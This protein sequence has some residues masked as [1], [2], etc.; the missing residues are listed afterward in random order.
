MVKETD[1]A[2]CNFIQEGIYMNILQK[3]CMGS[4]NVGN[5]IWCM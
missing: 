3:V 1:A 5:V 4:V 2:G